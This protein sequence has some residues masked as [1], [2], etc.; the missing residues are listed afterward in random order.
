MVSFKVFMEQIADP[1]TGHV[2]IFA[3]CITSPRPIQDPSEK[4]G[5]RHRRSIILDV[6]INRKKARTVPKYKQATPNIIRQIE[7][8][9]LSSFKKMPLSIPDIK[10]I[11]KKFNINSVPQNK[12]VKL[13]NIG[14]GISWDKSANQFFLHKL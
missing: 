11:A 3:P 13:K 14:L 8:L 6:P 7:Q 9:K 10:K 5:S 12:T 2:N 4:K 1:S